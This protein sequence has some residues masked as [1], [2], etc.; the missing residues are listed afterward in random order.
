MAEILILSLSDLASDPR[1]DRQLNSLAEEHKVSAAAFGP[2]RHM[3]VAFTAIQRPVD[4]SPWSKAAS[5]ALR[6]MR[7]FD[8]A[9]W[10]HPSVQKWLIELS[11]LNFAV[12]LV[13][14]AVTLPLAFRIAGERPVVFDA[15]EYAP[16]EHLLDWRWRVLIQPSIDWACQ[17]Y[18]PQTAGCMT[19]SQGI[20]DLY[21]VNYGGDFTVV[22]NAS[23]YEDLSP[24]PVDASNIKLVSWGAADPQ[25]KL[26]LMF[27]AME[28]LGPRFSLDLILVPG[29]EN[30]IEKLKAKAASS[31]S[32][33]FL[34]RV[35]MPELPSF[36]NAY[37]IGVFVLPDGHANQTYALPNKFFEFIQARVA[38]AIG[39]SVE[40]EPIA[41]QFDVGIV[42]EAFT[43]EALADAIR[44]TSP[45]RLSQLKANTNNAAKALNA[46]ANAELVRSVVNNAL[47][48]SG[49]GSTPGA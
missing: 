23:R 3:E 14:D 9:Y 44:A 21:E 31:P 43:A 7:C 28:L 8:H 15:H 46:E 33:R 32:I 45:E 42:A 40:M 29:D 47:K 10:R 17:T 5:Q 19:V 39:P 37:D 30:Y 27:D 22:T 11:G 34:P 16:S 4:A 41:N 2:P 13:N 25:R 38:V 20:A 12:I 48:T 35:P 49:P 18:I 26:E 24:Q 1:L 6:S 36:G